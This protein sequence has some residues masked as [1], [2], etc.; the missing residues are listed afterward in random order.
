MMYHFFKREGSFNKENY[1]LIISYRICQ[2]V[3]KGSFINK[4][5]LSWQKS[6]PLIRAVLG[7]TV[8]LIIPSSK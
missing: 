8:T 7:K 2:K 5:I 6:F 4:L 1:R 3:L